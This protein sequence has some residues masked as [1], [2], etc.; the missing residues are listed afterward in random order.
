MQLGWAMEHKAVIAAI[1]M[2]VSIE[3]GAIE[4]W[5]FFRACGLAEPVDNLGMESAFFTRRAPNII[6]YWIHPSAINIIRV[7]LPQARDEVECVGLM[8]HGRV[9]LIHGSAKEVMRRLSGVENNGLLQQR[10]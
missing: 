5:V 10:K 6:G 1:V 8:R 7:Y 9:I 3:A 4:E 2:G